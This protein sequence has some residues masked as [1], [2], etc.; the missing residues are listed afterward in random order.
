M[1]LLAIVAASVGLLEAVGLAA[2]GRSDRF[3]VAVSVAGL[4]CL[5]VAGA[6]HVPL[7]VVGL[8]ACSALELM[9]E[10]EPRQDVGAEPVELV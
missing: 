4:S 7:L 5:V 3:P 2:Q 6:T 10:V 9:G 1:L 8:L